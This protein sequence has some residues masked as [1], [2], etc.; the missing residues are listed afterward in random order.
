M[1]SWHRFYDPETGRYISADPIGLQG[2]LN[3]YA[4]AGGNP[5]NFIDP[6]GLKVTGTW[7]IPELTSHVYADIYFNQFTPAF[8]VSSEPIGGTIFGYLPVEFYASVKLKASCYDDCT[9]EKWVATFNIEEV[10]LYID[11]FPVYFNPWKLWAK[12]VNMVRV[13]A[14]NQDK[15][16]AL[17]QKAIDEYEKSGKSATTLCNLKKN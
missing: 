9:E 6:L 17:T 10:R 1:I 8:D 14:N 3:L 4:Y 13:A 11:Q 7:L 2:G 5:A 16:S 15:V 12:V